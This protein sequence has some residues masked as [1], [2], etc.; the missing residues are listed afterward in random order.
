M[1]AE[2]QEYYERFRE[3][4]IQEYLP[5]LYGKI[6]RQV[7]FLNEV[8]DLQRRLN[9]YVRDQTELGKKLNFVVAYKEKL[10][11]AVDRRFNIGDPAGF[12]EE[13]EGFV[14]AADKYLATLPVD[15]SREQETDR[16][17]WRPEDTLF[18]KFLKPF[19]R[20]FY[21]ISTFPKR[22][23]NL[24]RRLAGKEPL[25]IRRWNHKVLLRNLTEFYLK[26]ELISRLID[27]KDQVYEKMSS[28][29]LVMWE[30]DVEIDKMMGDVVNGGEFSVDEAIFDST[31]KAIEE[32]ESIRPLLE[33]GALNVLDEIYEEYSDDYVRCGTIE[34]SNRKFNSAHLIREH[35][36]NDQIYLKH[37]G[38]WQ[39]TFL[40]MSDDWGIDIDLYQVIF[41]TMLEYRLST[42]RFDTRIDQ[43]ILKTFGP[44]K[45]NLT[46]ALET[47]KS[48]TP[49]TLRA[50]IERQR[51]ILRREM[52]DEHLGVLNDAIL[53]Q[54][55]PSLV[56]NI[57]SKIDRLI[58]EIETARHIKSDVDFC[59]P[60]SSSGINNFSPGELINFES[61]PQLLKQTRQIKIQ[62]TD[63][64]STIQNNVSFL[65]QIAE[66]NLESAIS[67]FEEE[68]PDSEPGDIAREGLERTIKQITE[69]ETA[70]AEMKSLVDKE[71]NTAL[72]VFFEEL[73]KFTD[74][75]NITAIRV[76]MMKGAAI[77]KSKFL[78]QRVLERGRQLIPFWIQEGKKYYQEGRSWIDVQYKRFGIS[79]A[80]VPLSAE[81]A[82]FLAETRQSV[83]RLPFVYQRLFKADALTDENFFAGR[84]AELQQLH[85]AYNNWMKGRFAST[86]I[87]GE[88]GSGMTTL[89]NF[90]LEQL[91][92]GSKVHR[93]TATG[94]I[95]SRDH[96][97]EFLNEGLD[98]DAKTFDELLMVLSNDPKRV[99][100]IEGAQNC[101]MKQIGGFEAM[102]AISEL[103]AHTSR[104]IFWI[105]GYTEYAWNFLDKTIQLSDH[106]GYII[107]L[108]N[109]DAKS[110][111]NIIRKRHKV[112]GYNLQFRPSAS[113]LLRKKYKKMTE[114]ERQAFLEES[115][116]A[117]LNRIAQNNVS[118]ALIYWLRSTKEIT[119]DAIVI[120]SLK[121]FDFSFLEN[122]SGDKLFGLATLILHEGM[123]EANFMQAMSMSLPRARAILHPMYEDGILIMDEDQYVVNPLLYRQTINLLKAKNII[124]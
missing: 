9:T 73:K 13:F 22:V 106:F 82:D 10:K 67:L 35:E 120:G 40:L 110:I 21:G 19:K 5:V 64:L 26:E 66:F 115:Y 96:L 28:T 11:E 84:N 69:I 49:E 38:R 56:N 94:T 23:V 70:F 43:T 93:L 95:F 34:L 89:L 42:K 88:K 24:F 100:I 58:A 104:Q 12:D 6:D 29:S 107:R 80:D 37:H 124:H 60:T 59:K 76:R 68:N 57:E 3:I 92:T 86:A 97:L 17:K 30:H 75:D 112:S 91:A 119:D 50:E 77:E 33:E 4:M 52:S 114:P 87:V 105:L 61:Y 65:G 117:D 109:F 78:H 118:L 103:I 18:I 85:N 2:L 98:T 90:Y 32:I 102:R 111:V 121:D 122:I 47:I 99:I 74:N 48:A 72:T 27:Q 25:L 51:A 54:D 123:S 83:Q 20:I 62:I 44:W 113:D 14:K 81:L 41:N 116:F 39:N 46:K 53:S 63:K 15:L 45:D 1:N 79:Q 7:K 31:S 16:F 71:L 101:F 8:D 36:R 108:Q 55:L